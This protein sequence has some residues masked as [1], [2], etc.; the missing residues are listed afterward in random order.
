MALKDFLTILKPKKV[1][2]PP[3]EATRE[4]IAWPN[5]SMLG[6]NPSTQAQRVVYKAT[7]RNLR[8]FS[9]TPI[10]R[11]AINA[12]RNPLTQLDWEIVPN[13]GVE[14]NSELKRQ[15]E[16]ATTCLSLP[17]DDDSFDTLLMQLIDDICCGAGVL[18]I[19]VSKYPERPV[20][21]WPVDG[22]SVHIYPGWKGGVAEARYLQTIGYGGAYSVGFTPG[23]K[24]RD[25]EIVYIRPNPTT[26]S[27]FGFG[28]LEV[29]FNSVANQLATGKF[30]AKLAGNAL[31]PFMLDLGEVSS[32]VVQTW[33][34][35]WT[36]DI[37]GEG[38]IPIIGTELVD[39]QAGAGKTRGLNVQKLYPEGDK[40]LYLAY[41]EF[42]R[43]EIAA[44]FDISNMS[45]NVERDVNRSTAEVAE[46]RE[47]VQAIRP[48][49]R[50]IAGGLTRKV[51]W[52]AMGFSQIHFGWKGVDR[53][54]LEKT[55]QILQRYYVM[56]VFTPNDIRH[57]L[58][59]SP[60][61][62]AWGNMTKSDSDIAVAAAKGVGEVTGGDLGTV[63]KHPPPPAVGPAKPA[64]GNKIGNPRLAAA[65]DDVEEDEE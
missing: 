62:N 15:I 17:N 45:L 19:G 41:Q 43:T 22:L 40:A 36:N 59:E 64:S 38:K 23:I 24:L 42:L 50:M 65:R 57:K 51:I 53:E 33:R 25:D 4:T 63:K 55:S 6:Q 3:K 11:R 37:E 5:L 32:R 44:A 14:L 30:A 48:M 61:D 34:S 58:G 49:A 16:V 9:N 27:P 20:Y 35:Y 10:A 56:N 21:L 47:W 13:A 7:P 54:D 12:I 31:P 2:R 26:A 60:A 52:Q 28:P 29:S 46:D 18:E 39:G 1:G 8:Y